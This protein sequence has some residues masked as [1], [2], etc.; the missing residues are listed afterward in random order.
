MVLS[1]D[2]S[3]AVSKTD[4]FEIYYVS[5]E[6]GGK[7][8]QLGT[9]MMEIPLYNNILREELICMI[10]VEIVPDH[11]DVVYSGAAFIVPE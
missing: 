10:Q 6:N 7:G 3:S 4:K 1:N 5:K 8:S 9:S 2:K 11:S